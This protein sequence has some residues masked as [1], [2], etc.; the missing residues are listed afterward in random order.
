M[1]TLPWADYSSGCHVGPGY[2]PHWFTVGTVVESHDC[3][4]GGSKEANCGQQL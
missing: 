4:M 1:T 3:H 2:N